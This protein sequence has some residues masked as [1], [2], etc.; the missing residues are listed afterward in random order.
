M[1]Q[2]NEYYARLGFPADRSLSQNKNKILL[3]GEEIE[4]LTTTQQKILSELLENENKIVSF[5]QIAE[6]MWGD[7]GFEKFGLIDKTC[8]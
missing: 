3:Q 2:S 8:V 1:R 5:E 7:E 4:S 6:V